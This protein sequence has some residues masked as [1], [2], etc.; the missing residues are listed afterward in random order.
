M[1]SM[2]YFFFQS[3]QYN[4]PS[5]YLVMPTFCPSA[6]VKIEGWKVD[7]S[8]L[9]KYSQC[10]FHKHRL[11]WQPNRKEGGNEKPGILNFS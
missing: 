4:S 2:I 5:F 8:A 9:G 3:Y 11:P 7:I 6:K 10:F 1:F